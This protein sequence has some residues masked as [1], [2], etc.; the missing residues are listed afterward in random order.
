MFTI[1]DPSRILVNFLHRQSAFAW[2]R[3]PFNSDF[4]TSE[5]KYF[6]EILSEVKSYKSHSSFVLSNSFIKLHFLNQDQDF[7]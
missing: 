4:I 6:T 2:L 5:P 3:L 7:V 1:S